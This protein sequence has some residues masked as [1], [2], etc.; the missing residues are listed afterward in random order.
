[1]LSF[2]NIGEKEIIDAATG[3]LD[4]S[5]GDDA[6]GWLAFTNQLRTKSRNGSPDAIRRAAIT[7]VSWCAWPNCWLPEAFCPSNPALPPDR[8]PY[9]LLPGQP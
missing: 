8:E 3:A 5:L 4:L 1:M 6:E 2:M 7:I 9:V